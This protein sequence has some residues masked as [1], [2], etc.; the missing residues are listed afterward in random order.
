VIYL[1]NPFPI[2]MIDTHK[3]NIFPVV[4]HGDANNEEALWSLECYIMDKSPGRGR[5]GSS[6]IP[7]LEQRIKAW[8]ETDRS[9]ASVLK[10]GQLALVNSWAEKRNDLS[11]D[12]SVFI[13]FSNKIA[14]G[15]EF[16]SEIKYKCNALF[17]CSGRELDDMIRAKDLGS[18]LMSYSQQSIG[19][20]LKIYIPSLEIEDNRQEY[21]KARK[22]LFFA[23][24]QVRTS[25]SVM[26]VVDQWLLYHSPRDIIVVLLDGNITWVE[27]KTDFDW[28]YTNALPEL[29]R[30]V[31]TKKPEIVDMR[32]EHYGRILGRD[33]SS[34]FKQKMIDLYALIRGIP[35][36]RVYELEEKKRKRDRMQFVVGIVF[37]TLGILSSIFNIIVY[38][39][40]L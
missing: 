31:F 13:R 30:Y 3:N 36:S 40:R 11:E 20:R 6:V 1:S 22:L 39:L 33:Y 21:I 38:F 4:F 8:K 5:L 27:E 17:L 29:L 14:R 37:I 24:P 9:P 23:S 2:E 25:S 15:N 10:Y 34:G 18:A 16:D 19:V 12:E 26:N 35:V 7:L 32:A 28:H